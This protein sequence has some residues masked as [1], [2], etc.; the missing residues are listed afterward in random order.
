MFYIP[1]NY[2]QTVST[3][4][5]TD[6]TTTSTSYV[7]LLSTTINTEGPN[8]LIFTSVSASTTTSR[9]LINFQ[10]LVDSVVKRGFAFAQVAG[11]SAMGSLVYKISLTPGSHTIALQWKV[12][13]ADTAQIRMGYNTEHAELIIT[14]VRS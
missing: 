10:I 14:E 8:L 5:S 9:T 7:N 6:T 12:A 3:E 11:I 4:I 2:V 1:N 13:S